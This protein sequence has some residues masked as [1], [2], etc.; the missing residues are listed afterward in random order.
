MGRGITRPQWNFC[1]DGES[2]PP[3]NPCRCRD[4]KNI[5]PKPRD[6]DQGGGSRLGW[7]NMPPHIPTLW[8]S[9]DLM[10]SYH[11]AIENRHDRI[12]L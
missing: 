2:P 12:L 11:K 9:L 4:G 6:E 1:G 7:G 8:P 5:F 10:I 3:G